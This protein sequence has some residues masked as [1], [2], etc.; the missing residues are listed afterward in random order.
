MVSPEL[1][2]YITSAKQQGLT[3]GQIRQNLLAQGWSEKDINSVLVSSAKKARGVIR[4]IIS[5]I[6]WIP[7]AYLL[8]AY[9][10]LLYRLIANP[11]T[12][13]PETIALLFLLPGIP[14]VAILQI[15]V[16]KK[17]HRKIQIAILIFCIAS[18]LFISKKF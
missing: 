8:L 15:I 16:T 18:F 3:D 6:L 7:Q 5:G 12:A 1:Q 17:L 9:S 11:G 14:I 10:Q 2:N 13:H 4:N